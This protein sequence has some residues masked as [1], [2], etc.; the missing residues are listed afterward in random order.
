MSMRVLQPIITYPD[1]SP[2]ASVARALEMAATLDAHVTALVLEVDIPPIGN[3]VADLLLDLQKE[4]A[5]AERLSIKT[6]ER[7]ANDIKSVCHRLSIP[8]LVETLKSLRPHGDLVAERARR[9]D[10]TLL[11]CLPGSPDHAL[12]AEDVLFG[13][14]GPVIVFPADDI[15]AHVEVVAVAWD[16][17]RAAARALHDAIPILR[18]TS[19]VRLLTCTE[20]KQIPAASIDGVL[21]LLAAHEIPV[22]HVPVELDGRQIGEA[23]QAAALSQDAGLLVMGAFGHSRIREFVL[24][25]AT[26]SALALP[27]LPLFMSH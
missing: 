5:A 22:T 10:L 3:P 23:L 19:K 16:G 27:R 13:S 6:G 4:A 14:G 20:D 11:A 8:L 18:R 15:P 1:P 25:G 21:A 9:Y 2:S 7:A 24:G 17:T 12:L 26:S